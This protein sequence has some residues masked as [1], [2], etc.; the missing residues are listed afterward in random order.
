MNKLIE[1][2]NPEK[3]SISS[4]YLSLIILVTS[5]ISYH[6]THPFHNGNLIPIGMYE[7]LYT[8]DAFLMRIIF[9]VHFPP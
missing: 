8:L 2:Y 9:N 3:N 6:G 5:P 7:S 1:K 4:N